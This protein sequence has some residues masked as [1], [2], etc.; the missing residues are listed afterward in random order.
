M[1]FF[2]QSVP[3][4]VFSFDLV[5]ANDRITVADIAHLP[6]VFFYSVCVCV[7]LWGADSDGDDA[8][9]IFFESSKEA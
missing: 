5:R 9:F 3:N 7:C 8:D 4:R 6:L 1:A 2:C